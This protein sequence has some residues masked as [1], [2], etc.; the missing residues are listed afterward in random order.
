MWPMYQE[1]DELLRLSGS[2]LDDVQESEQCGNE[3]STE[4]ISRA[5]AKYRREEVDCE[6]VINAGIGIRDLFK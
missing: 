2:A 5:F 1:W 6:E 3:Q 4:A